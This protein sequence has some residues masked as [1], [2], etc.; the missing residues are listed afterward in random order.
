MQVRSRDDVLT[1]AR[2]MHADSLAPI[3]LTS[4]VTGQGLDLIRLFYNLLPQRTN[5]WVGG[6]GQGARVP[7]CRGWRACGVC[8]AMLPEVL[9]RPSAAPPLLSSPIPTHTAHITHPHHHAG[10]RR[11]R[12]PPSL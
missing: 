1:C 6:W 5:W 12:R 7:V 10:L 3:F 8:V 4:S 2:H 11:S 9:A